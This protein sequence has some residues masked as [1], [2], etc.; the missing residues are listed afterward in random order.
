MYLKGLRRR[1]NKI[2]KKIVRGFGQ[3]YLWDADW[4]NIHR[5]SDIW[6]KD[7]TIGEAIKYGG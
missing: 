6:A 2:N 5:D 4:N 3:Y 1:K 7:L